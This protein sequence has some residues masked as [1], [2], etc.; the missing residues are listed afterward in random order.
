MLVIDDIRHSVADQPT[1]EETIVASCPVS[2]DT[3]SSNKVYGSPSEKQFLQGTI[4]PTGKYHAQNSSQCGVLQS[5]CG[6]FGFEDNDCDSYCGWWEG[7]SYIE[8]TYVCG[9]LYLEV[10]VTI[11]G[12][13]YFKGE[14][15][16]YGVLLWGDCNDQDASY[17]ANRSTMTPCG[18]WGVWNCTNGFWTCKGDASAG[19][20]NAGTNGGGGEMVSVGGNVTT[21]DG[22]SVNQVKINV[23]HSSFN[24]K[25]VLTTPSGTYEHPA[26]P[27]GQ[28]LVIRP[29]KRDGIHADY[30]T[31]KDKL[32]I[33]QYLNGQRTLTPEEMLAADVNGDGRIDQTDVQLITDIILGK[34]SHFPVQSIWKF[35]LKNPGSVAWVTFNQ[36]TWRASTKWFTTNITN[37][38]FTAIKLGDVSGDG[39]TFDD[40]DDDSAL[41]GGG[42]TNGGQQQ[43]P[44]E[45]L[46]PEQEPINEPTPAPIEEPIDDTLPDMDIM[47]ELEAP[48][49]E[50]IEVPE[51]GYGVPDLQVI[52]DTSPDTD[53]VP[54]PTYPSQHTYAPISI[55]YVYTPAVFDRSAWFSAP[56]A[57]TITPPAPYNST[58]TTTVTQPT[59]V[60]TAPSSANGTIYYF[61]N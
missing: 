24:M 9:D 35:T 22:A 45:Y 27:K 13:K 43:L 32:F 53:Y 14:R 47:P 46:P 39:S 23:Y 25:N 54:Q 42:T 49:Q 36:T 38:D 1:A 40:G 59:Q 34:I 30:I 56:S 5:R 8:S 10:D 3:Q 6:A 16:P 58:S 33:Q 2:L 55:P 51:P 44:P 26:L 15:Y 19:S 11:A 21:R 50:P 48:V 20:T 61:G 7:N 29:E 17:K 18:Q 52:E 60:Y 31:T 28:S 57:I 41:K 37:L 12:K 4:W